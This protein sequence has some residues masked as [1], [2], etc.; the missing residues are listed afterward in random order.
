MKNNTIFIQQCQIPLKKKLAIK[1]CWG[2]ISQRYSYYKSEELNERILQ[3]ITNFKSIHQLLIQLHQW[4]ASFLPRWQDLCELNRFS[5][6]NYR[7]PISLESLIE[8][9]TLIRK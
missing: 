7:D 9:V 2:K 4:Y 6:S 1:T 3:S 8:E 5:V